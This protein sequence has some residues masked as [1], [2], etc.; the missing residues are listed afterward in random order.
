MT[1]RDAYVSQIGQNIGSSNMPYHIGTPNDGMRDNDL[2]LVPFFKRTK[3]KIYCCVCGFKMRNGEIF[4]QA[5][6]H[7]RHFI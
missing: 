4:W 7:I 3:R 2:F 1:A 5:Y 6:C